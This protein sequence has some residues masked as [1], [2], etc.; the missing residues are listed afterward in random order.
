MPLGCSQHLW[1]QTKQDKLQRFE[2]IS[3]K[4]RVRV[5]NCITG[6]LT[7]PGLCSKFLTRENLTCKAYCYSVTSHLASISGKKKPP[8]G[9]S[10]SEFTTVCG[11]IVSHDQQKFTSGLVRLLLLVSRPSIYFK[12]RC[13]FRQSLLPPYRPERSSAAF[14]VGAN[15]PLSVYLVA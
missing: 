15:S 5:G 12:A 6:I 11:L 7:Q 3:L 4:L 1:P 2:S 8:E 14:P 9:S 13:H 10:L